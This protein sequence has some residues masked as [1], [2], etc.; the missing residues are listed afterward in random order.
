MRQSNT[1]ADI[2][3]ATRK[4]EAM[5]NGRQLTEYKKFRRE[6]KEWLG[7]EGKNMRRGYGFSESVIRTTMYR[8]DAFHRWVWMQSDVIQPTSFT[9]RRSRG[10]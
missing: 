4:S 2:P 6:L 7:T 8:L 9:H 1:V 10:R 5:L 3:I